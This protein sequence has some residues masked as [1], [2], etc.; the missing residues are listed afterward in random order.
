MILSVRIPFFNSIS[1]YGRD[2]SS[3]EINK[4][5]REEFAAF[6]LTLKTQTRLRH[7]MNSIFPLFSKGISFVSFGLPTC[8]TK[9]FQKEEGRQIKLYHNPQIPK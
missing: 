9:P 4:K 6:V 5:L 2:M 3:S 1:Q 7:A 8:T